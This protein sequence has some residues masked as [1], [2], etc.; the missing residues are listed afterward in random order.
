MKTWQALDLL[1]RDQMKTFQELA[2]EAFAELLEQPTSWPKRRA[3]EKRGPQ[4][5]RASP[6]AGQKEG[7]R[8]ALGGVR[9]SGIAS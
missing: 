2:D 6:A 1:A 4:R 7:A 9:T 3:P 8:K 5:H